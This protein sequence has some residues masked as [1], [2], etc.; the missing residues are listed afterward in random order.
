MRAL[1]LN[2]GLGSRMGDETKKHPKCMTMLNDHETIIGRQLRQ[3]EVEGI[4]TVIITTG[5]YKEVLEEYCRGLNTGLNIE[6]VDNPL[7]RETNYIYSIYLAR[8]FLQDEILMIHGDLVMEDS[9]LHDIINLN[10][11]HMIVDANA[12]LPEK[13][14]KAVIKEGKI[15]K[16]G[17]SFFDH[18]VAAQPLYKLQREDW[19]I[20]LDEIIFYCEKS[21]VLC[22]AEEAFNQVSAQCYLK[23]LDIKGRMCQEIDTINDWENV[24]L[25]LCS[26]IE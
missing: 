17:V 18:A 26:V 1:I 7:F 9:V 11:S 3:L 8:E 21:K 15:V 2:S 12:E 10:G 25:I 20:W 5:Y 16:I 4:D 6:Y 22:Y 19:K 24:K 14:F 13:D 23:P